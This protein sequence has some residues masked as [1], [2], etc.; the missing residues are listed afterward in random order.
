MS[1]G[2]GRTLDV[3]FDD[4]MTSVKEALAAQGFGVLSEIDM[5]ATLKQ[6]LGVDVDRQTILGACN[7]PLAYRAVQAEASI[8]LLLPCNV[9]VRDAG[10]G[11]THVEAMDPQVMVSVTDN[12]E[13][14]SVADEAA[15]KLK[16][17]LDS[18]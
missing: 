8:G 12:A 1:Y 10:E 7:P 11:R 16:K 15:E 18:L 9:L 2:I 17:A 14:R 3:P 13:L 4:A 5:S 6:K